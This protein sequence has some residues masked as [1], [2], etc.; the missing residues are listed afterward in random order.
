MPCSLAWLVADHTAK[1]RT[2]TKNLKQIFL[3][4]ELRGHGPNF[5]IHVS[6]SDLYIP[7]IDLPILLQENIWTDPAGSWE[8][9]NRSRTHECG[10][11]D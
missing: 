3:E 2:N 6:V 8:Y 1:K 7:T 9:I 11:W 4:K 10:N 5:H